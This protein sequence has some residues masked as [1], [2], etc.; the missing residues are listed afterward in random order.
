MRTFLKG[1]VALSAVL[2][3]SG[4]ATAA[5][6]ITVDEL[7]GPAPAVPDPTVWYTPTAASAVG[8]TT[9][10]DNNTG[11][12]AIGAPG[13]TPYASLKLT[14]RTNADGGGGDRANVTLIDDFGLASSTLQN[15]VASYSYFVRRPSENSAVAPA[16]KISITGPNHNNPSGNDQFGTLIY[17]PVNQGS[18][19]T[20]NV[21]NTT[22]TID[23]DSGLF[24]WNGGFGQSNGAGGPPWRTLQD[25]VAL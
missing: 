16:L 12:A 7:G 13:P 23:F 2:G 21:W 5:T 20:G 19:P 1:S 14:T 8:G 11:L 10:I 17:E 25:W 6:L 22:P 9:T 4:M 24:W 18:V 3:L 15:I